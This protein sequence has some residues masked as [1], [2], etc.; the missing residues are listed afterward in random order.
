[1]KFFTVF[2][3]LFFQVVALYAT[4][5]DI[6]EIKQ[7]PLKVVIAEAEKLYTEAVYEDAYY[8]YKALSEMKRKFSQ[9]DF[10]R[11]G[12]TALAAKDYQTAQDALGNLLSKAKRYPLI[13]YEYASALKYT[14]QYVLAVQHFK[15]YLNANQNDAQND[16][17]KLAQTHLKS[18]QKALKEKE[19]TS[20]WFLDDLTAE[21]AEDGTIY[22]GLTQASK[23]KIGLIECQTIKGTCL[24]KVYPDN[25]IESLQ[26]SVG[27]PIFN[28][29]SPY[30][31][32]DGETVYFAQQEMGKIEYSI[33][34]GKMT[35][36]G[37]IEHIR[38]LGS[39]VNRIGYSSKHPTIGL[40]E[41]GQEIL[42]FASTLP[43]SQGGYD[44][45]YAIR[46]TDGNF[47]M[48]YNLGTRVNG[49]GDEITPFYYQ[50]DG[51]LYFSSEKT[52]GYGG[53]DVY[54]MTGEKKR[55]KEGQAQQLKSPVN[56]K[57]NDFHFKKTDRNKG[58][59]S[60]DR[61]KDKKEKTVKFKKIIGA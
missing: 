5:P 14:G 58:S 39:G 4:T 17:I 2:T 7:Q 31:A 40:T 11:L 19:K 33:F 18:C 56:S 61:G 36:T 37:E 21:K 16:Y 1:M 22:R 52:A 24:K 42:Y 50:N 55:W 8:Y 29:V 60:T 27:N 34:S 54:K 28:A 6:S 38:K 53:L 10:Y 57:G 43:G 23:Y 59:F 9:E 45:W 46:T 3:F 41:Q 13:H 30:I 20:S 35:V 49:Q 15:S 32:P 25:T 26:G 51:E 44:I 12:K 47:T 48:A